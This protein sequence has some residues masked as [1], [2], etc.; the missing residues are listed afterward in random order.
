[1]YSKDELK[2][3]TFDKCQDCGGDGKRRVNGI[4]VTN[5]EESG[6]DHFC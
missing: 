2:R 6:Q 5:R 1:M 3:I 4:I